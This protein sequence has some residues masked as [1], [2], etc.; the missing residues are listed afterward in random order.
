MGFVICYGTCFGCK[1]SFG[2]NPNR[3]PSI[4]VEGVKQPVCRGCV[5][6]SN[7]QRRANGLEEIV[8]LAGA[9][10]AADENDVL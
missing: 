9:Y 1:R 6:R 5:D 3:V 8:V 4:L 2:F 7:P 10:E